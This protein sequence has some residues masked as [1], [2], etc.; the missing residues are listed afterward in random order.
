MAERVAPDR[1][2]ANRLAPSRSTCY[3]QGAR[4]ACPR[5]AGAEGQAA[6][7]RRWASRGDIAR[8]EEL[9]AGYRRDITELEGKVSESV[10]RQILAQSRLEGA[11]GS[12]RARELVLGE[13]TAAAMANL[14]MVER[15]ADLAEGPAEALTLGC[16]DAGLASEFAALE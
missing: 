10:R 7:A 13:R 6:A 1:G 3:G 16:G 2:R 14:D 5:G 4:S 11:E 9:L 8:L 12:T 15:A